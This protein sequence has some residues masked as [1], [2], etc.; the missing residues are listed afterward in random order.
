MILS[1]IEERIFPEHKARV[2]KLL[3]RLHVNDVEITRLKLEME[4]HLDKQRYL[5]ERTKY[6][7]E[8]MNRQI[9]MLERALKERDDMIG[10][11]IYFNDQGGVCYK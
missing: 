1:F 8:K 2:D 3:D 11:E 6:K 5:A 4:N 7:M 10:K 9:D